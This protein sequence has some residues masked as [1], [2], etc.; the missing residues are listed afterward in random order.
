MKPRQ[1][2]LTAGACVLALGIVLTAFHVTSRAQAVAERVSFQ[3]LPWNLPGPSVTI[4]NNYSSP[5][6]GLFILARATSADGRRSSWADITYDPSI[7]TSTNDRDYQPIGTGQSRSFQ[8]HAG[9]RGAD[10]TAIHTEL[11]AAVFLDGASAG[12]PAWV[13]ELLAKRRCY[14]EE[15]DYVEKLLTNARNN[16]LDNGSIISSVKARRASLGISIPANAATNTIGCRGSANL[17]DGHTISNLEEASVGGEVGNPQ[18]TIPIILEVFNKLR[19]KFAA[20]GAGPVRR[21]QS[22]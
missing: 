17:V 7:T 22:P 11:K 12:E 10:P 20:V 5:I 2:L 3:Y 1:R 6:T 14:L 21:P 18:K 19:D 8:V 4:T 9:F 15:L 16:R 13:A